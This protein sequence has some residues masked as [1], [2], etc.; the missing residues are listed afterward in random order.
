MSN[1]YKVTQKQIQERATSQSF[2]RG[3]TLYNN[4]SISQIV[5]RGDGIEARCR[6]SY[7]EPYRVWAKFSNS[8][9]ISTGCTC[10]YDWGG[11]CKHI[12]AMLLT[13]LNEPEQF[14]D[15]PSLQDAL[16]SRD[17]SDLVDI[18]MLIITRYPDAQSIVDQPTPNEVIEGRATLDTLAM[19]QGLR[20]SFHNYGYESYGYDS[21]RDSPP[22]SSPQTISEIVTIAQGFAKRGDWLNTAAVYRT[23]LEEFAELEDH[24]YY[25]EDGELAY[26]IN[27]VVLELDNCLKQSVVINDDAERLAILEALLGVYIWDVNFGGIDMGIDAPEI[28]LKHA[29]REDIASIRKIVDAVYQHHLNREYG[30]WTAEAVSGF[31]ADL[32]TVDGVDPEIILERLRS[33]GMYYLLVSKLLDLQRPDEAVKVIEQHILGDY[34]RVKS[35]SLF[36]DTDYLERALQIAENGLE[37]R[38]DVQ[39]LT[40]LIDMYEIRGNE[41]KLLHWRQIMMKHQPL[42]INYEHLKQTA[43][44]LNQWETLRPQIIADLQVKQKFDVLT[45]VYLLEEE[46]ALAWET[47]AKVDSTRSYGRP[48]D[49]TVAESSHRFM[50]EQ[51]IPVYIKYARQAIAQRN[52]GQ[53]AVAASLLATVQKMYDQFDEFEQWEQLITDIRTEFKTLPALKD[54]LNKAG[55]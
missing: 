27:E 10:Q 55:L 13:F 51:A 8:E 41:E 14:E 54:E 28:I 42:A 7:P 20:D 21:Y 2:S 53:Y 36:L 6:G 40:W 24:E 43:R 4:D 33:Q 25:D 1:T 46:W 12:V 18:I 5:R 37:A 29:R 9:I 38:V 15:R 11:D 19:R 48:L 35:L 49:F 52:R 39:V 16:M 32:D 31:L 47:L 22:S 44:V 26:Q 30:S 3:K 23:I 34:E 17:K 50:P 45:H